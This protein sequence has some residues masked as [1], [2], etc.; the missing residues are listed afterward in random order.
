MLSQQQVP[1]CITD[2]AW[3][4]NGFAG[5]LVLTYNWFIRETVFKMRHS[6]HMIGSECKSSKS[7]V[8]SVEFSPVVLAGCV[9]VCQSSRAWVHSSEH[10]NMRA[11]T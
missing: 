11:N 10:R 6:W 1:T 3:P 9:D 7:A 4:G 8:E 2:P 5:L